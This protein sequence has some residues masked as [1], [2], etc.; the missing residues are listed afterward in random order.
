[1]TLLPATVVATDDQLRA[2]TN[3]ASRAEDSAVCAALAPDDEVREYWEA[4]ACVERGDPVGALR[5]LGADPAAPLARPGRWSDLVVLAAR[6]LQG[7]APALHLLAQPPG[8]RVAR[9]SHA[10][11][12]ALAAARLPDHGV[13]DGAWLAHVDAA[14]TSDPE[15]VVHACTARVARRVRDDVK[16]AGAALTAV[17]RTVASMARN[18][19]AL[20]L[21]LTERICGDLAARGDIAGAALAVDVLTRFVDR[22]PELESARRRWLVR[23]AWWKRSTVRVGPFVVALLAALVGYQIAGARGAQAGAMLVVVPLGVWA[24]RRW[25]AVA[26]PSHTHAEAEIRASYAQLRV[27][28]LTGKATRGTPGAVA[29]LL[30]GVF[31]LVFGVWAAASVAADGGPLSGHPAGPW[32]A[33]LLVLVGGVVGVLGPL[34]IRRWLVERRI[35]GEQEL[36]AARGKA[37]ATCEC[38]DLKAIMGDAGRRYAEHHLLPAPITLPAGVIQ[39]L[40]PVVDATG[41]RVLHCP[42]TGTVWLSLAAREPCPNQPLRHRLLLLSAPATLPTSVSTA[43]PASGGYL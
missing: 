5:V 24:W 39:R 27:N 23:G 38:W 7:D 35:R 3:G 2:W 12:L 21:A 14:E 29:G 1:M 32:V 43:P 8:D 16:D 31:G 25:G 13:A 37:G 9:A 36:A 4:L 26:Y 6:A 30:G 18:E 20:R 42:Q 40:A 17:A 11:L 33:G 10:R 28:P 34:R 41:V 15:A 22:T 19:P